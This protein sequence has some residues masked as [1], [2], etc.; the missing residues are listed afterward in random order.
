V[1][2]LIAKRGKGRV[3]IPRGG[4]RPR[5]RT[6]I[7]PRLKPPQGYVGLLCDE[8]PLSL[9]ALFGETA[10]TLSEGGGGWEVTE[11][12]QQVGMTTWKGSPPYQL[13]F[14]M[15]LDGFVTGDS[16]EPDI[17][18]LRAVW[19]GTEKVPPGI[20]EVLGI[21]SLPTD[22]WIITGM[23]ESDAALRRQDMS[24]VRCE[25][26]LTLTEYNPPEYKSVRRRS[27]AEAKD[28]TTVYTVK[29]KDTPAKIARKRKCKWTDLRKLNP[30]VIKRANQDLK[31]GSKIRVPVMARKKG[32]G[33]KKGERR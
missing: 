29:K 13:E 20:V 17:R 27:L 3:V 11:R 5:Q 31:D 1:A 19:R 4:F 33:G 22:E 8:P 28:R 15:M 25:V 7:R 26:T 16:V 32:K 30:G 12:P 14:S 21:P 23:T 10:P 18:L 2:E 24:R 9:L 6:P